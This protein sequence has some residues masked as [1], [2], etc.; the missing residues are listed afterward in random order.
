[1]RGK[2]KKITPAILA[3]VSLFMTACSGSDIP[4]QETNKDNG[5]IE[6]AAAETEI[7]NGTEDGSEAETETADT[8]DESE[9]AVEEEPE[10]TVVR[11]Q[12]EWTKDAV[13]YE[14]NVRQYTEEG[15]FEAFSEH[16]QELKD[17]GIT[18][19]WFMPIYPIS[20]T[21]RSGVLGSYY[22]ITDYCAVNPEFGTDEDFAALVAEAHDM[23]FHVMLDWVANHT[24]WDCAWI[25]EHP[26][27]YTQDEQGNVISPEGMGWPDVA[28]LNYDNSDMRAEMI[29]CMKYWVEEYDI[30]GFR[31]D[32]ANGVPLDFWEDARTQLE[33][34]KPIY[35]LAEDNVVK[36]LLNQAFDFNYNWGLYDSLIAVAKD[37]KKANTLKI[38]IPDNFPD[39]TYTLN[40]L[41]NHDKNS[42]E[43]TI[44]EG[45]GA[46]SL[47][48]M[49]SFIYTIPGA[50]LVYTGDEIGLDHKIAFMEKDTV[51]WE[52]SDYS[53]RELLARLGEIR[54][55]NPALYCGN[56]GGGI[57]Y[58]ETDNKNIFA[59]YR[60]NGD[61]CIKCIYNLSKREQTID[62][63]AIIDGTETV[64]LHGQGG[65]EPRMEDYPVSED[66]LD[67]E[68]TLQPWEFWIISGKEG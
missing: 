50:P 9:P 36:E 26:D 54:S 19:L 29:D 63:S 56:Y 52:S 5:I 8:G 39:G 65:E 53:Y 32:F 35:M 67:G 43:R 46:D 13:I 23:G 30:D 27:W 40:F 17:M 18:T 47:P 25:T 55:G 11:Y 3:A 10:E 31:C 24:G 15:T 61:N 51:D 12:P 59:F 66:G 34:I 21:K 4:N 6:S 14:V 22:S 60:Q 33:E 20:E 42:Y 2:M 62:V 38:Y 68:V 64:L 7:E 48:A 1:M 28:D 44:M 37:N 41:D 57:N 49:F 16:L 45:F 58:Y